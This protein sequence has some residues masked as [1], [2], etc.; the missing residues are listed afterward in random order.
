MTTEN[1][2]LQELTRLRDRV[3]RLERQRRRNRFGALAAAVT[4][5][6]VTAFGQLIVFAPDTPAVAA[7]VNSNFAQLRAW[8]EQKVGPVGS[9]TITLSTPLAGTQLAD[10]TV[11]GAKLQDSSVATADLADGAITNAKLDGDLSCPTNARQ[12]FGQCIFYLPRTQPAYSLTYRA[13]ANACRAERARLCTI[14]EVSAAQAAGMENCAF[15][16]FADRSDANSTAYYGYPMVNVIG[17]CGSPG[18][19][20]GTNA[21]GVTWGA[22]CCK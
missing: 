5:V 15:G 22:Y 21:M 4:L 20:L 7:E 10:G 19:N 3:E 13:A 16:W 18:L 9:S 14:A 6:S 2:V 17:G 1:D 11:S 8:L 12:Q